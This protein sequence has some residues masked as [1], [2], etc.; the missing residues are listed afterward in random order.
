M[1]HEENETSAAFIQ[2]V[3]DKQL[4]YKVSAVQCYRHFLPLLDEDE[5]AKLDDMFEFAATM[6][7]PE[8]MGGL[9]WD[10]LV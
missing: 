8:A 5:R 10:N 3:K 9:T 7:G 1:H 2:R 6:G 4:L